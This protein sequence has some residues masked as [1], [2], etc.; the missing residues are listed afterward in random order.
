MDED[1]TI[2]DY[3]SSNFKDRVELVYK[4]TKDIGQKVVNNTRLVISLLKEYNDN[5]KTEILAN[6]EEI[7]LAVFDL[8]RECIKF[9][10]SEQP[11]ASDLLYIQSTVRNISHLKR[12]G[13]LDSNIAEAI[14]KLNDFEVLS[15]LI[16]ELSYMA[17]YTQVMITKCICAFLNFDITM[18][19]ELSED[20]DKIDNLFDKILNSCVKYIASDSSQYDVMCFVQ[21]IFIARF[22]ERIADRTVAVGS[23]TI[24][25]IT[26]RRPTNQPH[27][28][29]EEPFVKE[30]IPEFVEKEN[31]KPIFNKKDDEKED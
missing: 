13:Y 5:V 26:L 2:K 23:R 19:S 12:I 6:S 18:A 29:D 24:Y 25:M 20:D 4:Q 9:L 30:D 16:D 1:Y 14:E 22:L 17:D 11:V 27:H 21:I 8:E 28:E 31:N 7:D 3:P 15:E 10:A